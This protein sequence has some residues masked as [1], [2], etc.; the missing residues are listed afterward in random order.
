MN[1]EPP[2]QPPAPDG[3]TRYVF[4]ARPR[5]PRC[6]SVDLKVYKT[7]DN[8]DDSLTR[9]TTC[10]SCGNKFLVVAE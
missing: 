5:C 6:H 3:A 7:I 1:H 9:Y 2:T 4:V 10:R 8:G